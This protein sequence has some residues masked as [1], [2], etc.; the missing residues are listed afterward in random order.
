MTASKL[1]DTF[2]LTYKNGYIII[3]CADPIWTCLYIHKKEK[4]QTGGEKREKT[5]WL[6]YWHYQNVQ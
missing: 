5:A 4:S 2:T 1:E 3:L 6:Y